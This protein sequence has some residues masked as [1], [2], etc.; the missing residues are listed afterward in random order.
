MDRQA[1]SNQIAPTGP[2]RCFA[3]LVAL[4]ILLAG[5]GGGGGASSG[6]GY[7]IGTRLGVPVFM[8][9]GPPA[10][11]SP[12]WSAIMPSIR[13]DKVIDFSS[14]VHPDGTGIYEGTTQV[15]YGRVSGSVSGLQVLV[16][17]LTNTNYI[18]PLTSTSINI[19]SDGTWI[20]PAHPGS[21]TALL[22]RADYLAADVTSVLPEI[23]GVNVLAIATQP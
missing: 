11:S 18:Q 9:P 4:L 16:Y 15:V 2:A 14:I 10:Y 21:V 7:L 6:N 19:N 23:D 12:P 20:A 8:Q 22:V 5:C 13:I 17:S 1:N 3:L